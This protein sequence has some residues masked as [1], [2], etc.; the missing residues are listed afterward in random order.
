MNPTFHAS[1]LPP[2][3]YPLDSSSG[4]RLHFAYQIYLYCCAPIELSGWSPTTN[5]PAVTCDVGLFQS[6]HHSVNGEGSE[7]LPLKSSVHSF[8]AG[9][10]KIKRKVEDLFL[11]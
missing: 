10:L 2:Y 7:K 5:M 9:S 1:L 3:D 6:C 11:T 8:S 4:Q